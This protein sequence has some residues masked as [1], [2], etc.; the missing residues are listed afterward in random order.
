MKKVFLEGVL[1][2]WKNVGRGVAGVEG[3]PKT[4]SPNDPRPI[5]SFKLRN[6]VRGWSRPER[7]SSSSIAAR[8]AAGSIPEAP[9]EEDEDMRTGRMNPD[10]HPRQ[11]TVKNARGTDQSRVLVAMKRTRRSKSPAQVPPLRKRNEI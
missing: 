2:L 11:I 4:N 7:P 10:P 8:A 3:T 1:D 6:V 9:L 5:Q